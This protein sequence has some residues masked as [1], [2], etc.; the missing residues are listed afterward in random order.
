MKVAFVVYAICLAVLAR[1]EAVQ[2][3]LCSL[4]RAFFV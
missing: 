4:D 1:I 3:L 2:P